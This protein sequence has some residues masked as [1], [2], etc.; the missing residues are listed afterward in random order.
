MAD[1]AGGE[2]VLN[3]RATRVEVDLGQI[4]QNVRVL[5]E[6]MRPGLLMAVVKANA[7]G[8]GL[9][10]VSRAAIKAGADYL[11][12][13]IPEEGEKLRENGIRHPILVLGGVNEDGARASVENDLIQTVFDP[14]GVMEIETAA[15]GM[16]K[17]A[18]AHIKLDTGMGRIGVRNCE[19]LRALLRALNGAP[20]VK[21]CGAFTHFANADAEDDGYTALQMERLHD[22]LDILPRGLLRHA[23]SSAA[24][25]RYPDT[26]FD[27]VR[28]GI[29]MYGYPPVETKLPLRPALS[30]KTEVAFVKRIGPGEH[31]SY[32]ITYTAGRPT[33]VATL[34]VGY[35]DGYR[36]ALS[37]RAFVLIDGMR[38]PV[39]GR[40]CMDQTMVDVTDLPAVRCGDEAVLLGTQGGEEIDARELA[41]WADTINYE[42]LLAP[43]SRVP[44][45]YNNQP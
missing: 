6:A 4:E 35:G 26:R 12:V 45:Y 24:L 19:E 10:P 37:G 34:P 20:H 33:L 13:A 21:L 43:S 11:A 31:V 15:A 7:Y 38:C 17:E 44:V 25:L 1:A 27:M 23:A 36:R 8:H 14:R 2:S 40:V 9:V 32:G 18:K 29:A 42:M 41:A 39:I 3:Y 22:M 16:R 5:K 28:A 30:W